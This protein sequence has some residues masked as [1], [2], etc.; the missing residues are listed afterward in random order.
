MNCFKNLEKF[1]LDFYWNTPL[2]GT[3]VCFLLP[4]QVE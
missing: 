3:K 4:N 1:L 2:L